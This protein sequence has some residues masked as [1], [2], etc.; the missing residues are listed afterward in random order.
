MGEFAENPQTR[1]FKIDKRSIL[2][3]NSVLENRNLAVAVLFVLGDRPSRNDVDNLLQESVAD[4]IA[5]LVQKAGRVKVNPAMLVLCK[6]MVGGDF[7]C[8][9]RCA[10]RCSPSC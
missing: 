1:S 6:G 7:D 4:R 3:R 9:N 2:Q 8:W 10:Q 5:R